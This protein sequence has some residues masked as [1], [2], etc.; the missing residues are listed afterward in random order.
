MEWVADPP[1]TVVVQIGDQVDSL[2]R[3]TDANWE[4]LEDLKLLKFTEKLDKIAQE[5]GGRF[6]SMIGNHEIMNVMSNFTYVSQVSMEKSGGVTGRIAKFKP[7]GEYAQLL[8]KRPAVLKIG[9]LLFCHAGLLPRHL[10]LVNDDLDLINQILS[11][12]LQD[13]P[14]DGYTKHLFVNL[15]VEG[16]SLLWNRTYLDLKSEDELTYVLNKTDSIAMIIGHNPIEHISHLYNKKLWITDIGL[17]RAFSNENLEV[18]EIMN[19]TEF[20]IVAAVKNDTQ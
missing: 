19:G 13:Q 5:K 20:R 2:V 16:D 12:I 7:G 10:A 17:S 11:M 8:S 15:F 6:I 9:K 1:N 18:L 3:D 4:K 14:V